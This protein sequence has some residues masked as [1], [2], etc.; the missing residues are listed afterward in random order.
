M[1]LIGSLVSTWLTLI[2]EPICLFNFSVSYIFDPNFVL[3]I[4][5]NSLRYQQF[6]TC[7]QVWS[8]AHA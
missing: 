2:L 4:Y 6:L 8:F 5:V 7:F 3:E 1:E